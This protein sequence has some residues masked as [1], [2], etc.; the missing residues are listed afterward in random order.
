MTLTHVPFRLV[1]IVCIADLYQFFKGLFRGPL[2][3]RTFAVHFTAINGA[4]KVMDWEDE[5]ARSGLV[6][7]AAAVSSRNIMCR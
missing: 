2:I 7:A 1:R 6:L 4:V 3:L 5:P